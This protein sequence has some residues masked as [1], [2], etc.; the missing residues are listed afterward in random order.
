[1]GLALCS[2]SMRSERRRQA[3]GV[4]GML[5]SMRMRRADCGANTGTDDK[6]ETFGRRCCSDSRRFEQQSLS[7]LWRERKEEEE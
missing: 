7:E 6:C 3:V 5:W 2:E 1:M 4:R